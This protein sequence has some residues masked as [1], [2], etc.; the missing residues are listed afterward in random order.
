[1]LPTLNLE[2]TLQDTS[3][4]A[5]TCDALIDDGWSVYQNT[6]FHLL[7]L[8]EFLAEGQALS[9]ELCRG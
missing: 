7:W 1:M 5:D 6:W 8:E 9:L 3:F 2:T 4:Y